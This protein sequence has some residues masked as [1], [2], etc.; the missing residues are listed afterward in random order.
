MRQGSPRYLLVTPIQKKKKKKVVANE[1]QLPHHEIQ[2]SDLTQRK[3]FY[4]PYKETIKK[5]KKI[6]KQNL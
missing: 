6:T 5:K 2:T 4:R 1:N 3:Q